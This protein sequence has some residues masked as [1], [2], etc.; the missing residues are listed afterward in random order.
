MKLPRY[1]LSYDKRD[2]KNSLAEKNQYQKVN[3]NCLL[4]KKMILYTQMK[5]YYRPVDQSKCT[6]SLFLIYERSVSR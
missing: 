2:Q 6:I 1:N 5:E 3:L 4:M